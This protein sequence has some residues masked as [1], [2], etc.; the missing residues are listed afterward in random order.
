MSHETCGLRPLCP[1]TGMNPG[2]KT[3]ALGW[4]EAYCLFMKGQRCPVCVNSVKGVIAM[5]N[6]VTLVVLQLLAVHLAPSTVD[7]TRIVSQRFLWISS[8]DFGDDF[9]DSVSACGAFVTLC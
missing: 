4:W 6:T 3:L 9:I 1:R 8:M 5:P 2:H 7:L